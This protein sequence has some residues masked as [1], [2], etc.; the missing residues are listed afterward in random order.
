MIFGK[1]P[2][3]LFDSL[4]GA[5]V[6]ARAWWRPL[7][8]IGIVFSPPASA[9]AVWHCAGHR[10]ERQT[11]L[12]ALA[13]GLSEVSAQTFHEFAGIPHGAAGLKLVSRLRRCGKGPAAFVFGFQWIRIRFMRKTRTGY[14]ERSTEVAPEE[15]PR[16]GP[17]P[18][19]PPRKKKVA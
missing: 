7:A 12:G 4:P 1:H 15:K 5:A 13:L 9:T 11:A 2:I 6:L 14:D 17:N 10:A 8:R 18:L 3:A 19:L 16:C